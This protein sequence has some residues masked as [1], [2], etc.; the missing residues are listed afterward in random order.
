[1]A[2]LTSQSALAIKA[3]S[4]P[5]VYAAPTLTDTLPVANL[6]WRPSPITTD[7]PEYTGS[8]HRPGP[9]VLG[10]SYDVSFDLMIRG[11]GGSLPPVA[12]AF[13]PGRV[14]R[15]L[16]F[17]ENRVA[18]AIPAAPEALGVGSTQRS[19]VLGA[20]AAATD[21]LYTGLM[22]SL[23]TVSPNPGGL[24]MIESYSVAKVARIAGIVF[25]AGIT[26]NY[27][28]PA[29][30]A[31]TLTGIGTPPVLSLSLWQGARRYNFVDMAPSSAR[32]VIPAASRD[33]G[34]EYPRL[35]LTYS[36]DLH[37]DLEEAAPVVAASLPIPPFQNGKFHIEG[38]PVGGSSLSL[39][40]GLRV[41]FPP[42]PNKA[43]G[44]APAQLVETR[45][46][47]SFQLN[48]MAKSYK[49]MLAEAKAQTLQSCQ[50]VYGLGSGNYVGFMA[51]GMR[52]NFPE[53]DAGGDFFTTTG[54]AYVDGVNKT[55]SLTF[56][57]Y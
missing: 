2:D 8:I 19:A 53:T 22:L 12:D 51:S 34:S 42:D 4:A 48:Q 21:S 28:I 30:L 43:N 36:G 57:Y 56:P 52:F 25:G 6:S 45:R 35:S 14:L 47:V 9:I 50:A 27:Q 15:S 33:G 54:E 20:T 10:A 46:T 18:A 26:G 7:N 29:Q 39:D 44:N 38:Q 37:S 11:P 31:Y 55:L 3:Q 49:D 24:H 41:G 40:L 13:I 16:G 1:M 5:A 23:P 32:L 17:T